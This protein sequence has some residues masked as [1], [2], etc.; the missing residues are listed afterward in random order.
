[1]IANPPPAALVCDQAYL[2]ALLYQAVVTD[3]PIQEMFHRGLHLV[4]R[5][6]SVDARGPDGRSLLQINA[7][8]GD[9]LAMRMLLALGASKEGV[10]CTG[11]AQA[12]QTLGLSRVMAATMTDYLPLLV[13]CLEHHN[14]YEAEDIRESISYAESVNAKQP[15]SMDSFLQVLRS[16]LAR[17]EAREALKTISQQLQP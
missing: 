5:G 13:H 6:A 8:A 16:G 15:G 4:S 1:M 2:D 7:D 9:L 17:Q 11:P 10:R 3:V 14:E 12:Q